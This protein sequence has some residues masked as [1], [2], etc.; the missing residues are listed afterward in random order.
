MHLK[1]TL[2]NR[3]KVLVWERRPSVWRRLSEVPSQGLGPQPSSGQSSRG[4]IT[5]R[6]SQRF[7]TSPRLAWFPEHGWLLG[8]SSNRFKGR[9]FDKVFRL[10]FNCHLESCCCDFSKMLIPRPEVSPE[11]LSNRR[12]NSFKWDFPPDEVWCAEQTVRSLHPVHLQSWWLMPTGA[13]TS[14]TWR[15]GGELLWWDPQPARVHL[16]HLSA[17]S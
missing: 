6:M 5:L 15:G 13:S 7:T 17:V 14:D 10:E 4:T 11:Q 2:G 1:K 12:R 3:M 9:C 16:H 8:N